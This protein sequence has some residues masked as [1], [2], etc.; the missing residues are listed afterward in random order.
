[1]NKIEDSKMLFPYGC[2]KKRAKIAVY[3]AG[4][5]GHELVRYGAD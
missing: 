3:G 5:F 1:M 4:R 2:I